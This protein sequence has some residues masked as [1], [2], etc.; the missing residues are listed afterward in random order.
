VL[1][2][3][4]LSFGN[5]MVDRFFLYGIGSGGDRSVTVNDYDMPVIR[6]DSKTSCESHQIPVRIDTSLLTHLY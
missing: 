6:K 4:V 3:S 5:N 1:N 2:A